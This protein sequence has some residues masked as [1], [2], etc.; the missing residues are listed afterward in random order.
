MA[1]LELK[2]VTKIFGGLIAVDNVTFN[3]E[4]GQIFGL[5]GPNG[6][7]KTTVFN[8]ITGVYKPEKGDIIFNGSNITG[9]SPYKIANLGIVRTFQ[10]IRLFGEMSVAENI[11]SGRHFKSKQR[12]YHGIIHTPF[13]LKDEK[14]NWLKVYDY[15]EMFNLTEYAAVSATSLPYGIQRKVE[16]ARALA[17]EPKLLILDEPAAGLNDK[18]TLELIDTII[19]IRD[20]GV[21]I[22]LIEH[23]MDLVMNVT[24]RIVVLNFGK[25]ISEGTPAEVQNDPKVIEAY[26][27][28]DED[29]DE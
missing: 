7:G 16:M 28:S 1:L 12:W 4:E 14:E 23:D 25:K 5:I 13:S 9:L 29:D 2:D 18:E 19:K 3:V 21:T 11:M 22:L 6:A 27:G 17:A 20:M 15:M 26:L 8:C 10:T 24:D